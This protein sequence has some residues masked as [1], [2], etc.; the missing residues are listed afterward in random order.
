VGEDQQEV[1]AEVAASLAI[2]RAQADEWQR[3]M[4]RED[5]NDERGLRL[6]AREADQARR[7]RV[8]GT[9]DHLADERDGMADRR[10]Q[11]A[12]ERDRAADI[13]DR[14]AD[15]RDRLS[16][17]RESLADQRE[18]DSETRSGASDPW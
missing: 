3:L 8:A 17:V 9:R 14:T 10:D 6:S 12:D 7:N 2:A 4:H 13:R 1:D 15:E 5:V 16:D 18:I 11:A